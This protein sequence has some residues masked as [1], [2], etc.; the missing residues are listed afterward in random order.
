MAV[1]KKKRTQRRQRNRN[2]QMRID[3]LTLTRCSNC[4]KLIPP[5]HVCKY[6]GYY[7]E[8]KILTFKEKDTKK[9]A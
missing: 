6:C 5:H 3:P 2:A 4:E 1:P 7:N 8:E 9:T